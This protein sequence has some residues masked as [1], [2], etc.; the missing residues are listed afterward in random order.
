M[1]NRLTCTIFSFNIALLSER[2]NVGKKEKLRRNLQGEMVKSKIYNYYVIYKWGKII[3]VRNIFY[4][5]K[6]IDFQ[7]HFNQFRTWN[8]LK[9]CSSKILNILMQQF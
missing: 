9:V 1:H 8:L 4:D 5:F 6:T 7:C 2:A 3:Q